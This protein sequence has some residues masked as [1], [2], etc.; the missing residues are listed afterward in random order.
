MQIFQNY[1]EFFNLITKE[2]KFLPP[3][4]SFSKLKSSNASKNSKSSLSELTIFSISKF[5]LSR[6]F[7]ED[8]GEETESG[9]F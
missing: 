7:G 3:L 1:K 2:I 8:N 5:S 4:E 6:H 9:M